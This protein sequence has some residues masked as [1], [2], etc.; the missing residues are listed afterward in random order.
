MN[1]TRIVLITRRYWPLIGNE[2]M[3]VADLANGLA[4]AGWAPMLLTAHFDARWPRQ[5]LDTRFPVERLPRATRL[6]REPA[7]LLPALVRWLRRN[8]PDYDLVC[9]SQLGE[10]AYAT[11]GYLQSTGIPV[12]VRCTELP[13]RGER[14]KRAQRRV[15]ERCRNSATLVAT[16]T[17]VLGELR[18][19]GCDFQKIRL[20][21]DGVS[22][23][24]DA[25]SPGQAAAR[26][27]LGNVNR[28]LQ[29]SE[30][31]PVAVAESPLETSRQLHLLIHAWKIVIEHEP[32]AQLWIVGDGPLRGILYQQVRDLD[33]VGRVLLPG[34]FD[35]LDELLSAAD[36]YVLPGGQDLPRSLLLAA[37]RGLPIVAGEAPDRVSLSATAENVRLVPPGKTAALAESLLEVI[38]G[39]GKS[40]R[41]AE[42]ASVQRVRASHSLDHMV[43]AHEQLFR[44]LISSSGRTHP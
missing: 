44:E 25:T 1:R 42:S 18:Q 23:Q 26:Q 16:R 30:G 2:E 40:S 12:V 35:S 36:L 34:S 7:R 43:A 8:R 10:E 11:A 20:I 31:A 33:L 39:R 17:G 14:T 38:S 15:L 24:D 28:D 29:V 6:R 37:G 9:V 4:K 5:M 13:R 19:A 41:R 21:P 22:L 3:L 32:T 27:A